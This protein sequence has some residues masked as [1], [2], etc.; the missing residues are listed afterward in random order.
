MI[1]DCLI[2]GVEFNIPKTREHTAKYCSRACSDKAPRKK[3]MVNCAECGKSFPLKRS[4]AE[5]SKYWGNFCSTDCNSNFRKRATI[6]EG[7]PNF[8]GRNYDEDGY[9]IYTPAA[10]LGLGL[11]R[12]KVHH[13]TSFTYLGMNSLPK[14]YHIHH[15]DC[16]VLNNDEHNLQLISNNDH[17]WIHKEFGSATLWA[18]EKGLVEIITVVSW[19]SDPIRAEFLLK[20]NLKTQKEM[21]SGFDAKNIEH[22]NERLTKNK[23]YFRELPSTERGEGG[24]GSTGK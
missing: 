20:S 1:K 13:A 5:R 3:N 8:K 14:G 2:C 22:I 18:V 24:Y 6:G 4:Q 15:K 10:S 16:D 23:M 21:L 7:N 9:R 11:G 19:S 17:K 12:I